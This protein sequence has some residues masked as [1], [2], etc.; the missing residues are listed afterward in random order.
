MC[1]ENNGLMEIDPYFNPAYPYNGFLGL[2]Y[3]FCI[4]SFEEGYWD[5]S[6]EGVRLRMYAYITSS[7]ST[8]NA[9]E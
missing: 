3:T 5:A 7:P 1:G 9:A 2:N 6:A 4:A 8:V